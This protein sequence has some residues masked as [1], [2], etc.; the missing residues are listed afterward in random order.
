MNF[1]GF[2]PCS[3]RQWWITFDSRFN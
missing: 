3:I 2:P 1:Q